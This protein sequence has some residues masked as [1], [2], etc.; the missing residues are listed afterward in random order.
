MRIA[1]CGEG[2]DFLGTADK[3][4]LGGII[5]VGRECMICGDLVTETSESK[6]SIGDN[7]FI[8][9][10]SLLDCALS[11]IL[12]NDVLVAY[13]CILADSDNHSLKAS[14]RKGDL[15]LWKKGLHDW[16]TTESAPIRI[17][18]GAWLGAR[19]IILKGVTVGEGSI[20]GAGSVVTRDVPPWTVAAGNPAKIVKQISEK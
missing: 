7:V 17:C 16:S 13:Q 2:T 4:A 19:V 6:I 18:R 1:E 10:N 8:G 3:R 5:K 15:A 20:V 9:G 11:I 14:V 12:E